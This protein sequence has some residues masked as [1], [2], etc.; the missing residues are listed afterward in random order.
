MIGPVSGTGR[1]MMASLQQAVEKG[2]PPDQAVQYVKSMATQGVAPLTDLYSMM[3]QFQRLKQ[4][5]VKAPQT[6]PTIKDQLNMLD[7]QQRMQGGIA[8]MQAP[9]PAPQPMDRGLGAID[10]GRMEYPQFAGGGVVALASGSKNAVSSGG[11]SE[12]E[13]AELISLEKLERDALAPLA[14]GGTREFSVPS[15]NPLAV[16]LYQ[17]KKGRLAQLRAKKQESL[18][19]AKEA[20]RQSNLAAEAKA[21]G[22]QYE[23]PR[24]PA[25]PA[26]PTTGTQAAGTQTP[27]PAAPPVVSAAP[28]NLG[29]GVNYDNFGKYR[30]EAGKLRTGAEQEANLTAMQRAQQAEKDLAAMGIGKA[31]EERG[32]YLDRREAEAGKQLSEDRRM[33]LAQA[34][35]AMAEA[36]SRRG[37]ERTGFLGAVAAGGTKGAQ[38]IDKAVRENRALKDSIAENRFALAQAQEMI[39]MGNYRDGAAQAREAKQNLAALNQALA[40]NELGISQFIGQQTAQDRRTAAQIAADRERTT[41]QIG[42]QR[43]MSAAQLAAEE[44]RYATAAQTAREKLMLGLMQEAPLLIKGYDK[45]EPEQQGEALRALLASLAGGG[46]EMTGLQDIMTKYG[47]P[48]R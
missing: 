31:A 39:K 2:M 45:M 8:G 29:L 20:E 30:T 34:G 3:N 24:P 9:A 23:T 25:P 37:R 15:V 13:N 11:F 47:Q 38:L 22:L 46:E 21:R 19:A 40:T 17:N 28:T 14:V 27:P 36:A 1:A 44:K 32:K 7:Q 6:P 33:A 42:A 35:F 4:Q 5:Q 18:K 16:S 12:E 41:A 43:E 26:A 48:P 10:A